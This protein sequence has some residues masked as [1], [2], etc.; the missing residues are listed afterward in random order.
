LTNSNNVCGSNCKEYAL[1]AMSNKQLA[2]S[3]RKEWTML[4]NR[5]PLQDFPCPL[6]EV[7]S[8]NMV[9]GRYPNPRTKRGVLQALNAL[10]GSR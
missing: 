9:N 8:W 3:T 2:S 10:W 5:L 6:D 4:V 7:Q 1:Y